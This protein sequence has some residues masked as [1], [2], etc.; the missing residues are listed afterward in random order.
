M[1]QG[2]KNQ[3]TPCPGRWWSSKARLRVGEEPSPG[4]SLQESTR[5]RTPA[6]RLA[7][8]ANS[9]ECQGW[10]RWGGGL[11]ALAPAVCPL[12]SARGSREAPVAAT[13]VAT[14]AG[15]KPERARAG[16]SWAGRTLRT[17]LGEEGRKSRSGLSPQGLG[18]GLW[19]EGT[20]GRRGQQGC[21]AAHNPVH[22]PACS[23]VLGREC[24]L[25][26]DSGQ[27]TFHRPPL[28]PQAM[29]TGSQASQGVPQAS[30][31]PRTLYSHRTRRC[32]LRPSV[33]KAPLRPSPRLPRTAHRLLSVR[34]CL[35]LLHPGPQVVVP[36]LGVP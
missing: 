35:L 30:W 24:P 11:G 7:R 21:H 25:P 34:A 23:W 12:P 6:C 1:L 19:E 4:G 29:T 27:A 16:A 2:V 13:H 32:S 8:G 22:H 20:P 10:T 5:A 17:G 26:E 33:R 36:L 31:C 3:T 18:W 9:Q 15:G 28:Q 14:L